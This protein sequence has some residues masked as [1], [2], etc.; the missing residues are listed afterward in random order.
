[1]RLYVVDTCV[2]MNH[3]E[4]ANASV[5]NVCQSTRVVPGYST[6]QP[7]QKGMNDPNG[8]G[9]LVASVAA[10]LQYGVAK[11]AQIIPVQA[12]DHNGDARV[13]DIIRALAWTIEDIRRF[14][15]SRSVVNMS[16]GAPRSRTL[17]NLVDQAVAEGIMMVAAAG[18]AHFIV[19]YVIYIYSGNEGTSA[20]LESPSSSS[21]IAVGAT[22]RKDSVAS[23]SNTGLSFCLYSLLREQLD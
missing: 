18:N 10:G 19:N 13:S 23:F 11:D 8:H 5:D 2:N 1:M 22:D 7:D 6:F 15:R 12:L 20:C 17:N 3:V 16:F 14:G 9:T 21:A 4:F